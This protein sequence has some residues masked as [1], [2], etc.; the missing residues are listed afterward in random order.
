M[1]P[2]EDMCFLCVKEKAYSDPHDSA[3][4]WDNYVDEEPP[5][6]V[7]DPIEISLSELEEQENEE[8]EDFEEDPIDEDDF[9]ESLLDDGDDDDDDD[10]DGDDDEF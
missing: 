10:D 1:S 3:E 9:D 2:D 6:V 4:D 5:E 8:E 7:E